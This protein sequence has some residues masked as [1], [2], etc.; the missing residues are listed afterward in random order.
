MYSLDRIVDAKR[1]TIAVQMRMEYNQ[2]LQDLL[3]SLKMI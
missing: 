3:D 2:A 1:L